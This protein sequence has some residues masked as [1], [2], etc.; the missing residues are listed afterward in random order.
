MVPGML[1]PELLGFDP[2]SVEP[3]ALDLYAA[4][5]LGAIC[6]AAVSHR[7]LGRG[8]LVNYADLPAAVSTSIAA[9]FDIGLDDGDLAR[10]H[11]VTQRHAKRPYERYDD[12]H[13]VGRQPAA[14]HLS[15]LAEQWVD[16]WYQ[17]LESAR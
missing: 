2:A 15:R 10:M 16:P 17:Q 14:A 13:D 9:H 5:V 4:R 6:E 3:H 12:E 7:V 1:E 8:M 11:A